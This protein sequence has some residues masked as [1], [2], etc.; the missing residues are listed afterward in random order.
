MIITTCDLSG[1]I[2]GPGA[3]P[4]TPL[5]IRCSAPSKPQ[6]GALS[7]TTRPSFDSSKL[8]DTRNREIKNVRA[9]L[10]RPKRSFDI[11]LAGGAV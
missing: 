6:F 7:I 2:G 9:G 4:E 10:R 1:S 5:D 11:R 8:F 3:S